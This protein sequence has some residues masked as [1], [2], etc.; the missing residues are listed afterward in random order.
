MPLDIT[1]TLSDSDL[2]RFQHIVDQARESVR[3]EKSALQV[4]KAARDL[5]EETDRGD[6]PE[7]I[8]SRIAKLSVMIDMINDVEWKL[9]A[10]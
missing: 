5:I 4:E 6:L 10:E 1:F 7:F 9:S 3:D 2:E 8:T